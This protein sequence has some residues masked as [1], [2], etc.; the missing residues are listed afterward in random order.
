MATLHEFY[1]VEHLSRYFDKKY[2]DI[3][4]HNYLIQLPFENTNIIY[5]FAIKLKKN[6]IFVFKNI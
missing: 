3:L 1:N 4:N 5:I 2:L 6:L